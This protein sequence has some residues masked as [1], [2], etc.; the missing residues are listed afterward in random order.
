MSDCLFTIEIPI[1]WGEM[2]SFGHLNNIYYF[3][4]FESARIEFF[5]R[6][7][8]PYQVQ[9]DGKGIIL[10]HTSC[11]FMEPLFYPDTV[12]VKVYAEKVGT[13]SLVLKYELVSRELDNVAAV[14]DSV[15]VFYDYN[16]K[17]K[18]P[19]PEG[20]HTFINSCQS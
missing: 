13:T 10:A 16:K 1:A 5:R 12:D 19:V 20:I 6:A 3:R 2:D 11:Q 9:D 15:V 7:D 14:G 18:R 8:M 4:Y 17:E